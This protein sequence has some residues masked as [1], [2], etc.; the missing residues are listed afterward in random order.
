MQPSL[1]TIG[2]EGVTI[3]PFIATLKTAKVETLID[4]RAVPLSRR[5]GF[6][7]NK[8][9]GHLNAAGIKYLLLKGLGTPAEGRAAARKGNIAELHRIYTAH[10]D[11]LEAQADYATALA[12]AKSTP[13]CLL[14]FEHDPK[15]CHRLIVAERM[16]EET[17]Q[18]IVHLDPQAF[19]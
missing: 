10:L 6:S 1:F 3:E 8:L 11:T 5:P 18:E 13:S 19:L 14:C 16:I 4:I 7:K 2:Y 12:V 17:G 9:A 15:G